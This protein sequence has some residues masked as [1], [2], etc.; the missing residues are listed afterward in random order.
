MVLVNPKINSVVQT[1]PISVKIDWNV[2]NE[3]VFDLN[4]YILRF[5]PDFDQDVGWPG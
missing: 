3:K 2:D 4:K 1:S 5:S